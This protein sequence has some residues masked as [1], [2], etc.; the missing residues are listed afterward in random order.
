MNNPVNNWLHK[1]E[2]ALCSCPL[3]LCTQNTLARRNNARNGAHH[4]YPILATSAPHWRVLLPQVA[5][6]GLP[7]IAIAQSRQ[8]V[9]GIPTAIPVE[10]PSIKAIN[11]EGDQYLDSLGLPV[12]IATEFKKTLAAFPSRTWI[13]DNSGSMATN[14]GHRLVSSGG[15]SAEISSS[16]WEE[17]GDAILWH[18]SLA[19][20]MGAPTEF[21]LLNPPGQAIP[22][23]LICGQGSPE[24]EMDAL[25]RLV[26]SSPTGR[27]PLC[28]QIR[29]VAAA[30]APRANALRAA[31]QRH[32][33]VRSTACP[34]RSGTWPDTPP[35]PSYSSHTPLLILP[36]YPSR[37]DHRVGRRLH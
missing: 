32:A 11:T 24:A 31:G 7:P 18:G 17:L 10:P 22:Q 36:S 26:G 1:P 30:I 33:V 37:A 14:D 25:K 9:V 35:L 12:G 6:H 8:P 5:S 20:Q 16:R 3:H 23:V 13:I 29:E 2:R 15:K 28:Q 21:R 27:T 19:A 4:T 34:L